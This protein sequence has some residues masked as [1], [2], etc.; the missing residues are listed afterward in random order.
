M[1]LVSALGGAICLVSN[2]FNLIAKIRDVP[3]Q[4]YNPQRV[5]FD[6]DIVWIGDTGN[7]KISSNSIKGSYP[8]EGGDLG[9]EEKCLGREGR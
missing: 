1:L 2:D 4:Y 5:W 9:S 6:K 7:K 3:S 8:S